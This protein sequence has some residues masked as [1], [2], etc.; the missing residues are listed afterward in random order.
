MKLIDALRLAN[1]PATAEEKTLRVFLA[2]G[3]TPLHLQTFL[4]AHWR[5]QQPGQGTRIETGLFGD[6]AGSLERLQ[7]SQADILIVIIEWADLDPRLGYRSLGGWRPVD[8]ADIAKSAELNACRLQQA[9]E[10]LARNMTTVVCLPT[11]PLPPAFAP[12]PIQTGSQEAHLHRIVA[13]LADN[14][15]G[16]QGI[17]LLSQQ[18][19]DM[20]SA[21]TSRHDLKSDLHTGFPYTL[22]HASALA[23]LLAGLMLDRPPLKGLITDLDDTLWSGIVGDDGVDRICWNLDGDAQ[24]HG[25]YQQFL[26]SLAATGT[27]IAVASKNDPETVTR[28]FE[29]SDLLVAGEDIFPVEVH[30][31]RKSESVRRILQTWNVS[32][33]AVVFVDDS[34]AEIAEVQSAFPELNCRLFPKTDPAGI[35]ALLRELRDLFGKSALSEEDSLRLRSIRSVAALRN[36]NGTMDALPDELLEAA[37]AR[38]TFECGPAAGGHRALELVNKTNQFNLNGRRYSES[39]WRQFLADPAGFLITASYEDKYGALGKIAVL[40]GTVQFEEI[41]VLTW[42]MSCRAFSRRIE[43]QCL[44]YLFD[45]LG[46]ARVTLDYEPTPRNKPLQDFLQ[47]LSDSPLEGSLCLTRET[48]SGRVPRL[49]HHVEVNV[50]A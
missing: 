24:M 10:N 37:G 22:S 23:E 39:E 3:F 14:L 49:F 7:P 2:C 44:R 27:L 29:R 15:A 13:T 40:L 6:L 26:S 31:S 12:R 4:A 28:A 30:W 8:Q 25:V 17:R 50:H 38:L 9:V 5:A 46:A 45:E 42:V 34:P 43:Y 18:A 20:A 35:L 16:Y 33:D 11:L 19:V 48:F 36:Q 41:R 1:A 47:T 21:F 32:A